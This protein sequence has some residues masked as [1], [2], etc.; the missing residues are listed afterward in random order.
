MLF[1]PFRLI[2]YCSN[3]IECKGKVL[4]IPTLL[5]VV[6]TTPL[7]LTCSGLLFC[8]PPQ[9][10][11]LSKQVNFITRC[12]FLPN[13]KQLIPHLH[14]QLSLNNL[15]LAYQCPHPSANRANN[16][17]R[18]G[19]NRLTNTDRHSQD[20]NKL[21]VSVPKMAVWKTIAGVSS[22]GSPVVRLAAV[23]L[24]EI[25][26]LQCSASTEPVIRE[27]DAIVGRPSATTSTVIVEHAELRVERTAGVS[28]A[29][30]LPER[31]DW[32]CW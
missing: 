32:W 7:S 25:Q 16:L 9:S 11:L 23:H 30:I 14:P 31:S 13:T 6:C 2:F 22:W 29:K 19:R 10:L 15:L 28:A 26:M 27:F 18:P 3:F 24:A 21:R 8:F 1:W 5:S 12:T 20:S 17:Q 4:L